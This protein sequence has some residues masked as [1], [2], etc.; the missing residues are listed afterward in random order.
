MA[1]FGT[2]FGLGEE[3][4]EECAKLLRSMPDLFTQ[5]ST[6]S[7]MAF[8]LLATLCF[9][10]IGTI[11]REMMSWKWTWIASGYQTEL[12]YVLALVIYQ[13]GTFIAAHHINHSKNFTKSKIK[14]L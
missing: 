1:T 10:A 3:M 7:F 2:L 11:K 4:M 13:G 8:T 5:L 6:Y 9:S 12:V 14:S